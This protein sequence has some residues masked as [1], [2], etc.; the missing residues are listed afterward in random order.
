ML[1][2]AGASATKAITHVAAGE[3]LGDQCRGDRGALGEG[4]AEFL[5]NSERGDPE[6]GALREQLRR[7]GA[8]GI[9][10]L[11]GR[12]QPLLREVTDGL[13]HHQLLFVGGDVEAAGALG[14]RLARRLAQL[15]HGG[16]A[17]AGGVGGAEAAAGAV[18]DE[19]L[20]Q[21]SQTRLVDQVELREP[22]EAAEG[23]LRSLLSESH[24][25]ER[26]WEAGLPRAVG[27][28]HSEGRG[29]IAVPQ[30]GGT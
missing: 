8:G 25:R 28:S 10:V 1:T 30:I 11:G 2:P 29:A 18:I 12:A 5:G 16:E 4:A 23:D 6:L 26:W 14:A 3:R 9:G 13:L 24:R 20:R 27:S 22:V 21:A 17:A 7:G 15:L 19:P